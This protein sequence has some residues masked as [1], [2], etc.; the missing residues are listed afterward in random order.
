MKINTYFSGAGLM[1]I[2][3]ENADCEI[4]QSFELDEACCATQ[5]KNFGHEVVS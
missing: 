3:L 2:G 1:E 5:R 4:Q